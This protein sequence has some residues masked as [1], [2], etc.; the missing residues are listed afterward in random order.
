[1][2]NTIALITVAASLAAHASFCATLPAEPAVTGDPGKIYAVSYSHEDLG[3]A[4]NPYVLRTQN[5][6]ENLYLALG[7]CDQSAD[8]PFDAQ[9]RWQQEMSEPFMYFL[10]TCTPDQQAKLVRYVKEGR[11]SIAASHATVLADRLNPE[12]AARLF[13]VAN[14]HLPDMLGIQPSRV[15]MIDDVIG[16]PWSLPIYCEAA[17]VPYL[18]LGH[19]TCAKCD[20]LESAPVVKWVGPKGT[21]SVL[22][23]GCTYNSG[24]MQNPEKGI[25][26]YVKESA[27]RITEN[28]VPLRVNGHD[29][30]ITEIKTATAAKQWNETGSPKV[31]IATYDM[32]LDA[33]SRRQTPA[34]TPTVNKTGPCQWMD[35]TASDA[36]LFGRA[37]QAAERLPMAEKF[38]SFAMAS[39]GAAYPWFD[40]TTAWHNLLSNYEHT[41]GASN[42]RCNNFKA[43]N[44]VFHDTALNGWRQYETELVEHREEG[45]LA[46]ATADRTLDDALDRLCE[47]IPV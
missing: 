12:S 18:V 35:Q 42:W 32:Y 15:A 47:R 17:Q 30:A 4:R 43:G 23:F 22:T 37:R 29:F 33:L 25:S 19:N 21:G 24:E 13:Y 16:I 3:Y 34:K 39:V 8:W 20:E 41:I 5:R 9:Y 14:R 44:S 26:N 7:Y 31:Q 11:I 46:K 10:S 27:K 38:S 28:Y 6:L 1:M 40:F 36:W 45:L 2:K